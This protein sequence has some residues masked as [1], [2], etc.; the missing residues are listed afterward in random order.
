MEV[1]ASSSPDIELARKANRRFY[2]SATLRAR[3]QGSVS[4]PVRAPVGPQHDA[5]GCSGVAHVF[6]VWRFPLLHFDT[7]NTTRGTAAES[8]QRQPA[9]AP[10]STVIVHQSI[11]FQQHERKT[12]AR[13]LV[14]VRACHEC[15]VG[16]PAAARV[17]TCDLF[18]CPCR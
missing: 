16:A 13:A 15:V 3:A 5:F 12:E 17:Q 9:T 11:H 8:A 2:C 7:G 18:S 1:A 6:Q 4:N 14:G 10:M